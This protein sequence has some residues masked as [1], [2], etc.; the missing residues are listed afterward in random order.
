MHLEEEAADAGG[1]TSSTASSERK[2]GA[3]FTERV[4]AEWGAK[5]VAEPT[6]AMTRTVAIFIFKKR[7]DPAEN[8]KK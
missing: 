3:A 7:K 1:S 6:A 8:Q 4:K 5:A 2:S